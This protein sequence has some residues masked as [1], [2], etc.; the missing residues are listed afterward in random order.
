[1]SVMEIL[2]FLLAFLILYSFC[3]YQGILWLIGRAFRHA[4]NNNEYYPTV[5]LL[6]SAYNEEKVIREK[7]TNSLQLNYPK[8]K[9]EIIVISD[10]SDD[11]T[12]AIVK[13]Y[14]NQGVILVTSKERR[15]KTAGL[16]NALKIAS[17]EIIVFTDA[18]SIFH[19]DAVMLMARVYSDTKVGAVTGSTN[20]ISHKNGEMVATSSL[21]TKLER[22]TKRLETN[23]GSC[24]GADGAIFSIRKSLFLQLRDDDINDLVIP[25]NVISQG[26]RVIFSDDI[27]CT[28]EPSKNSGSAFSRQARITN[29]TLRALFRR[30]YLLNIF[31]YPVFSFQL[32]SHKYIRLSVPFFLILIIPVNLVLF[33]VSVFYQLCFIGQVMMYLT[34]LG[35]YIQDKDNNQNGKLIIAYHFM[36]VQVSVLKG[37]L[38]FLSGKNRV[39]WNPRN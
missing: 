9:L 14:E 5:T 10:K 2:F 18:D 26:Y 36:M 22:L 21:Y 23:I 32:I 17:S 39:T 4:I 6:I 37:W 13:E 16:N 34:V 24:V 25:L 15:G 8:N 38:D 7:I 35:G 19:S 27:V 29:R 12:D 3:F 28:E 30:Y 33:P 1:M 31:K 20:Y 11:A